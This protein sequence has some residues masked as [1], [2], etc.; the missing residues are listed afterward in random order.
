MFLVAIDKTLT[1]STTPVLSK[2]G[3]NVNENI[4]H[5]PHIWRTVASVSGD[6]IFDTQDTHL[7]KE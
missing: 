1:G 3:S 6:V 7:K 4:L 2:L 5:S